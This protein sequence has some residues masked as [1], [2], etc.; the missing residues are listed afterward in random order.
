MGGLMGLALH[1]A[2]FSNLFEGGASHKIVIA[3][4]GKVIIGS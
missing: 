2:N 1:Q 3:L 4:H